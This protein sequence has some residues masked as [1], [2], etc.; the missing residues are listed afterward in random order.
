[1]SRIGDPERLKVDKGE[2]RVEGIGGVNADG[3]GFWWGGGD[4][5]VVKLT[6]VIIPQPRKHT[7]NPWILHFKG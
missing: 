1:M 2:G 7:K 4:R 6:V 3:T 5:N